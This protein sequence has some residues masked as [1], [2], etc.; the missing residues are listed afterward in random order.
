MPVKRP[1]RYLRIAAGIAGPQL[2]EQRLRQ[3]VSG[4]VVL[5]TGA[6]E[7]IGA[8][9]AVRLGAAGAIV[10]LVAR[11]RP[12]LDEVQGRIAAAG[13]V[14][15]VHPADL[16]VPEQAEEFAAE[17]L[18]RYGRVDIVVSNAGRS[19][20]RSVADT[21]DRFHDVQRLIAVNHLGPVQLLLG[22]LPAMRAR[23][24]GHLVNVS[25]AALGL[26][27]AN[28]SSYLSSKSA[29]DTWLRC[30]APE[31]RL[32]GVTVSTVHPGLVR[33]RMSEPTPHYRRMPA[34][35]ADEAA[36]VVCRAVTRRG[37]WYPW[38][39]RPGVVLAAA[40][41]GSAESVA[42]GL[43]RLSR[44]VEPLRAVAGSGLLHPVRLLRVAR[45]RRRYGTTLTTAVAAGPPSGPAL[46]DADGALT[47]GELLR[48]AETCARALHRIGVR[49]GG[50]VAVQNLAGRHFATAVA[51]LGRL[52]VTA[53]LLPPDLPAD[54]LAPVLERSGVTAVVRG[55]QWL[56]RDRSVPGLRLPE[57]VWP[58]D[59]HG[60]P[61]RALRAPGSRPRRHGGLVVLTS[62]TTGVPR[63]VS[64]RLPLR[65]LAGP[66]AT[67]LRLIPIRGGEPI[68]VAAPPHHGYGLIYLAAGLTVGAPVI[69]AHGWEP[70]RVL[71][72]AAGYQATVL[73]LLPVQLGRICD[74]PQP[75]RDRYP[76]PRLRAVVSGAAPLSPELAAKARVV[77]GH[78][79][80]NLYGSTEA[81]WAAIATPADLRAAPGTV[82]RPPRGIR[83]RITGTEGDVVPLGSVGQVEVRGWEPDGSWRATGDLGRL[84]PVGRLFLAGRVDD[85]IVSGG[86]NVYPGPVLEAILAY[87]AVEDAVLSTVADP[88]F[89]QRLRATV[90]ARPGAALTEAQL[91]NWLRG[92]LS[93]AEQPR[94]IV[95]VDTL[96]RTAT[97]KPLRP[98]GEGAAGRP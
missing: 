51:G 76:L 23:G 19:I 95:I 45:A 14:A 70:E 17:L 26:P 67:H 10:L 79:L 52:G 54:R 65:V 64:R 82:G 72:E 57:L 59:A 78:R 7:G 46:I 36:A 4:R 8:A 22:L 47:R 44:T 81:G 21:A 98:P 83:L 1:V 90:S 29:F 28:W 68:V 50:R 6:S 37:R 97:G 13:G 49:A 3:A 86:E 85:M 87:P 18:Q 32:D 91:R 11:T 61:A 12:R 38:W 9:T 31:L 88:E 42:T 30:A 75:V 77:F 74:L 39:S 84:D 53:V 41:P 40:L 34:M 35:T 71:S 20:R 48:S 27:S 56:A 89:G 58:D 15:H 5:V 93:R 96:P 43:L 60:G 33:T 69:M 2:P 73:I 63:P 55:P 66:A 94:D 62:G 92:R 80:F 24:R 25:T 16:S